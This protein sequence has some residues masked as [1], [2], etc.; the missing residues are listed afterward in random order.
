M[1]PLPAPADGARVDR[2]GGV[3]AAVVRGRQVSLGLHPAAELALAVGADLRGNSRDFEMCP[4]VA[5]IGF[6]KKTCLMSTYTTY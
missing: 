1:F 4:K 6:L 2:L 5:T 3:P